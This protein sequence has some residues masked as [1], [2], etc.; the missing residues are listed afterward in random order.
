MFKILHAL[1]LRLMPPWMYGRLIGRFDSRGMR[2]YT[3]NTLW[4]LTARTFNI[5]TSFVVTIYLVRYLGPTNYG[6]LSYAISFVGIF[7]ILATLGIDNV[8]YRDLIKYPDNRDR[9]LGT[10]FVIRLIAG[11]VAGVV[12]A[13]IGFHTNPDE[14]SRMIIALLSMTFVFTSFNIITNEFQAN[15]A[16]KYPSFVT[17]VVVAILN[18]LKV[19][20]IVSG[21]GIIYLAG[22][23]LLEPILYAIFFSYIRVKHYGSF[24]TWR[25]DR[26][27]ARSLIVD[28]WP[29]IFIAVFM[30]LYS[31]I[32]Q[33]MLK[34]MVDSAAVGVY[35]AALRL[36]EAWLFAPAIIAS[37]LFPAI[38][39]A[40]SV[41]NQEYRHR[42]LALVTIFVTMAIIIALPL[43]LF[44][45]QII[46]FFYGADFGGS[47]AVFSIYI[48][49]GVWAVIDIVTRNFL[50]VENMRKTIFL[51]TAGTAILNTVL[52]LILIPLYGPAGA[53]WSTFIS[54]AILTMP[55]AMIYRL[56]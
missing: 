44:S 17:M 53:A 45:L 39:N 31:R 2:R 24:A 40:K 7:G 36:A 49:V 20:V 16:Q 19:G 51:L 42:L 43:S 38:V 55:L 52:N 18:T 46:E 48:W 6:E 4:A 12:T 10:A 3:S 28:A 47:G 1:S 21:Q 41:N 26:G 15:V 32:D 50:I 33:I 34:H 56:K 13:T 22:I 29:F 35:D 30:A 27:V 23:L 25:F 8:L 14:L 37:S 54:Y 5:V 11:V 9:Y